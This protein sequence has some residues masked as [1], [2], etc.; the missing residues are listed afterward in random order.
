MNT[1][2]TL[3]ERLLMSSGVAYLGIGLILA[4]WSAFTWSKTGVYGPPVLVFLQN[5]LLWPIWLP[6]A[7]AMSHGS[8]H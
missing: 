6:A 1:K 7:I 5:M 3:M 8:S 4:V 2:W